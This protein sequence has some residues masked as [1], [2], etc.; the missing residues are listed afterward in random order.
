[1]LINREIKNILSSVFDYLPVITLTGPR[2]SGKTTLCRKIFG[3]LPYVNLEDESIRSEIEYDPKRFL[4]KYPD[5]VI[6]DEA[7]RFSKI[8]SY[9]QVAV[10]DDRM[11]DATKRRYI[12]TGSS[13]FALMQN[14]SQS[15]AGRT[16]VLTLLPLSNEEILEQYSNV[17]TSSLILNGGYPAVWTSGDTARQLLISNYYNTYIER[18][19]RQLINVKD[20]HLFNNFVRLCAGRIGTEFNASALAGDVGVSATTIRSWISILETSYIIHFV[21]PY[22]ANINKRLTKSPKMFF[23]DTGLATWLMGINTTSQLDVHPL[24]G[25]L[26]ENMVVNELIKQKLNRG[27]QPQL[28]F[29]RDQQQHEVDILEEMPDGS[30]NAYEVKSAMTYRQDFFKHL[31]YIRDILGDKIV[32]TKVIYDGTQEN[33]QDFDG[34]INFRSLRAK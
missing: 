31:T 18:D 5:G 9:L 34:I 14:V 33:N 20:L 3:N 4:A 26:F 19:L 29:Y 13:N 23:H 17:A 25:S 30:L 8:F 7:Q 10:D 1:M 15:M 21:P 2:Q 16:A 27:Q 12:V 24:R 28:Y 6:I 11:T 32:S 22:Y